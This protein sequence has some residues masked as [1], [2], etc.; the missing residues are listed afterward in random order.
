MNKKS[1]KEPSAPRASSSKKKGKDGEDDGSRKKKP[2]KKKDPNAPKRA[3]S[4][5]M[6]FCQT[7]REVNLH[8]SGI[9]NRLRERERCSSKL[10]S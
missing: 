5:F 8:F 10:L 1:K 9:H 4:A 2:K 7:E 6:F 3:I